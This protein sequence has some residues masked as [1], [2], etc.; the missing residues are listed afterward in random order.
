M[1]ALPQPPALIDRQ[2][3][4]RSPFKNDD[5]LRQAMAIY[6]GAPA[7]PCVVCGTPRAAD[8]LCPHCDG[9]RLEA[10]YDQTV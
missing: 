6:G 9:Q 5:D 4:H 1:W 10:R 3:A 8:G 7:P 2:E